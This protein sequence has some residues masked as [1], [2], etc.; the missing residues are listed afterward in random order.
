MNLEVEIFLKSRFNGII[1]IPLQK[2]VLYAFSPRYNF[3]PQTATLNLQLKAEHTNRQTDMVVD[4]MFRNNYLH[5]Y[6]ILRE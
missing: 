3:I 4:I 5:K 6:R 2:F 1:I